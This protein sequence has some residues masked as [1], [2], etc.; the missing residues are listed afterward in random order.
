M[1]GS[2]VANNRVEGNFI[3]LNAGGTGAI[4]NTFAGVYVLN[5]ASNNSIVANVIS[6]NVG[7]GLRLAGTGTSGNNLFGNRIGTIPDGNSALGNGFAGV[8]LFGGTT[9]NQVGG[10]L[11][12]QR[13]ILSG[14]GTVGLVFGDAGTSN[15]L[16]YGNYIGTNPAGTGAV[17]NGFAGVYMTGGSSANHLGDGP[18]TGNLISANNSVGVFVA[19]AATAGNFI[20]NNTI[21]LSA[22]GV[23]PFSNQFD[24][25]S[26]SAGA[27]TTFI[28]G[29]AFGAANTISGNA[30]RGIA[31]F[32][33][34]TSMHTF[35][36]NSID[37]N[38]QEGIGIYNGSNHSQAAPVLTVAS[39]TTSTNLSGTLVGTANTSFTVEFFSSLSANP[40]GGRTYLGQLIVTTNGSGNATISANLPV[41]VAAGRQIS[42]TATSQATGDTSGFSNRIAVTSTDGDNDGLPNAYENATPGLNAANPADA[43]LDNDGDGFTNL[44]EFIA[45]TNPN[46][47][48]S[49]LITTGVVAGTDFQISFGTVLGKIYRVER[50]ETLTSWSPVA[51]HVSGT[52]A[53]V[54][55]AFPISG[56]HQFFRVTAGE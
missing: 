10:V 36:R 46:D 38:G 40:A 6:G 2:G 16:A 25:I 12:E 19:D 50:S 47:A 39:L 18:G 17:P 21:G 3:G 42:A 32:D 52:G 9:S 1:T 35:Q 55:M 31:V 45:G 41:I 24:G 44:Q 20:R 14:N 13:N 29:T 26:I 53:N 43:N 27:Q 28:G 11:P 8:T 34:A 22:T 15:N 7:E 37:G 48:T 51:I 54:Q 30:G 33:A 56:Q 23:A 4:A 5:G 49:R